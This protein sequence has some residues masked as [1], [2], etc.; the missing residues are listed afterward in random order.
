MRFGT[1]S[2]APFPAPPLALGAAAGALVLDRDVGA[3]GIV[4][5]GRGGG[6]VG[7]GVDINRLQGR[8]M[9]AFVSSGRTCHAQRK[10]KSCVKG[11][12]HK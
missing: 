7:G 4:G 3:V 8:W 9:E 10:A 1:L 5:V 2:T 11:T 12:V 6:G